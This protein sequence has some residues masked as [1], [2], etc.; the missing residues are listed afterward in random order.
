MGVEELS[1]AQQAD[2]NDARELNQ[3]GYRQQLNVCPGPFSINDVLL[4]CYVADVWFHV[5]SGSRY[6]SNGDV[7]SVYGH[8]PDCDVQWWTSTAS[9]IPSFR[10]MLS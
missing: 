9:F 5:E 2:D 6:D 10:K 8:L 7:G 1:R 3:L 4:R